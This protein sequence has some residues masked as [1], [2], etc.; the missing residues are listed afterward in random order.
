MLQ[1]VFGR[2]LPPYLQQCHDLGGQLGTAAYGCS[3][4][5]PRSVLPDSCNT[6]V[7]VSKWHYVGGAFGACSPEEMQREV[8]EKGPV[9]VS[10]EPSRELAAISSSLL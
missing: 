3:V 1:P 2:R 5:P 8:W 10:I 9:A 7:R 6:Q 4:P